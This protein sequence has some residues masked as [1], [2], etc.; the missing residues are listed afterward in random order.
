ME[1]N[2]R[3]CAK[4]QKSRKGAHWELLK[5]LMRINQNLNN[6]LL[7]KKRATLAGAGT[8]RVVSLGFEF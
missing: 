4:C 5:S 2:G 3:D 8:K 7:K 6:C 1:M